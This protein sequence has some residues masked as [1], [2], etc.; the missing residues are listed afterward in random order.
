MTGL[1]QII[2]TGRTGLEAATAA[3]AT[4]ANNT[5]NVNT[6]GYNVQSV[7]Q[8]QL[9][10]AANGPGLGTQVTSIQRAYDQFVFAQMVSANSANQAAQVAQNSA[11]NL[12]AVF[13]VA[14]GGMGGLGVSITSFFAGMAGISQDP[15][16]LPNRQSFLSAA[17][18]LATNFNSIGSQLAANLGSLN[19]Q[20]SDAVAQ[21]NTLTQQIAKLNTQIEAQTASGVTP[22]NALMDG[23][24]ALVTQLGGEL[25]VNVV[26]G[27][28]NTVS[29]FTTGGAMLVQGGSAANLVTASGS[30]ADSGLSIVYQPTGQNITANLSGGTIGGVL[31]SASQLVAA[32]NSV[33]ALA[34]ALASAMNTQQTLGLDL[35]GVQGGNL[36]AVS[37]PTVL[38][39]NTN[40]GSGTLTATI[41]NTNAFLPGNF[42]IA[43]TA[44]GYDATNIAT[45][46]VTALGGGPSLSLDG[47]SLTV[48]GTI[49]TGDSF[50]IEPTVTAA[51]TLSVTAT[52]PAAIAAASPYV[53]TP[54]SNIGDVLA[55]SFSAAASGSLPSGAVMVPAS[56]FGQNL[57]VKF[58]SATSFDVLSASN[59]LIASGSFSPGGG[60]SI[61]VAYPSPAPAGTVAVVQL[62]GGTPAAGDSFSL[63]PG[64]INSNGNVLAM[65]GLATQNLVSGQS[66]SSAYST[67]V[68][69][70]G[71]AG[72]TARFNAQAA[73]GLLNQVQSIQQSISGVN[74]DE[75]AAHLVTYQQAYQ[76][77]AQIIASAQLLFQQLLSAMQA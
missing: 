25:G 14:S 10:G 38:A 20:L 46:Q 8:V 77:A 2:D 56:Y 19:G 44:S 24:D 57:T 75:Q 27:P 6:P 16:S 59:T 29:I 67:L 1:N 30:Y 55:G 71:S 5:A 33:G 3:L 7:H 11:E 15:T 52:N 74:L 60:A 66:L 21:V 45:G 17:N 68:G 73:Q 40:T 47:M 65:T 61:A 41:T 13:P 31:S 69:Q 53:A 39:S 18:A 62:S 72:Q 22:P 51:Q 9:S 76:A 63:T 4:V 36:F 54:G 42:I 28:N 34:V 35:N 43:K 64:G 32:Q 48:S 37:G 12:T 26:S 50:E 70:V 58:T 49:N 23:R